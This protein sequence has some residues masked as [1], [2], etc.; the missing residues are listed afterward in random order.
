M[1]K[2]KP[3]IGL[4]LLIVT[5]CSE[6]EIKEPIDPKEPVKENTKLL[7][8]S[9]LEINPS[10]GQVITFTYNGFKIKEA[11][12]VGTNVG[13]LKITYSYTGDLITQQD[14]YINDQLYVS[15]EYT[16]ENNKLKTAIFKNTNS[17][18]IFPAMNQTKYV[19][20][21]IS[22]NLADIYIY[23]YFNNDWVLSDSTSKV[24]IYFDNGNI[25]KREKFN[26]QGSLTSTYNYEYDTKPSI[27]KNITG[28]DKLYFTDSF[29]NVFNRHFDIKDISNSNNITFSS[30]KINGIFTE[31]NRYSYDLNTDGYPKEKRYHYNRSNEILY[32]IEKNYTYY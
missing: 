3:L 18:T 32:L 22:E 5:S 7:V 6:N 14:G 19:Y 17:G 23:T 1:N 24:K 11:T 16:Y 9:I 10:S 12:T 30:E 13:L 2:L 26:S 20:N 15:T 31:A 27:Y 29:E 8:K 4:L 28:F 21:Y 25:L